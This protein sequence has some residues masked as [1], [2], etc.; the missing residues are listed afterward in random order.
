MRAGSFNWGPLNR[1]ESGRLTVLPDTGASH[2]SCGMKRALA[3]TRDCAQ[4]GIPCQWTE[5][6]VSEH[7][8]IGSATSRWRFKV[9]M[10]IGNRTF[11]W[12]GSVYDQEMVPCLLG[13]QDL[14]KLDVLIECS[15]GRFSMPGPGGAKLEFSPGTEAAQTEFVA[16]WHL[17]INAM[18]HKHFPVRSNP[19][20]IDNVYIQKIKRRSGFEFRD[21]SRGE[22]H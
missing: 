6:N 5:T 7:A 1:C 15:T 16:H 19:N 20:K 3:A 12:E 22:S 13:I 18:N 17:P 9:P 14:K 2:N 10:T 4:R 11:V 21:P 8:G